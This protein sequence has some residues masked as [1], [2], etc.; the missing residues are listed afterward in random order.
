MLL[1]QSSVLEMESVLSSINWG[2]VGAWAGIV[3]GVISAIGYAVAQDYRRALYYTFG[4]CITL[5]VIWR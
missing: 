3:L 4:V 2:E 1:W 5:C